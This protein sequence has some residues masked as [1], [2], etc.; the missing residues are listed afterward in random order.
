[1]KLC[2]KTGTVGARADFEKDFILL[3]DA[4]G[5]EIFVSFGVT[6]V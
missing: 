5:R 1:M 2:C 4:L 6:A 3:E